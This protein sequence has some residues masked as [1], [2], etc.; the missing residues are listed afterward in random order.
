MVK[1]TIIVAFLFL[2]G[3]VMNLLVAWGCVVFAEYH[4]IYRPNPAGVT[5]AHW[6]WEPDAPGWP[7][8]ATEFVFKG[9]GYQ[10]Q[11]AQGAAQD[12]PSEADSAYQGR[13]SGG[14]PLY[15]FHADNWSEPN[16]KNNPH[17][18]PLFRCR[19]FD[20]YTLKTGLRWTSTP[21]YSFGEMVKFPVDPFWAGFI[22]NSAVY[23]AL[24]YSPFL[25][26]RAIRRKRGQC[27]RCA[28][29]LGGSTICPECGPRR[30][31]PRPQ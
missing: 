20:F 16:W 31:A 17:P 10:W 23:A 28:Y 3:S 15:S 7:P 11:S 14:W 13:I 26:R 1:R 30:P 27:I 6:L 21:R 22:G 4:S 25:A 2:A 8:A 18:S 12:Q 19:W 5:P 24:C 29:P 9:I